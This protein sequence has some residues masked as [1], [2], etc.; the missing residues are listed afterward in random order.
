MGGAVFN[1]DGRLSGDVVTQTIECDTVNNVCTVPMR[2]PSF[3]LIFLTQQTES[4]STPSYTQ[5]FATTAT[6]NPAGH[7][8]ID[9]AVLATMNGEGGPGAR[10]TGST[11]KGALSAGI[12]LRELLPAA[13][14]LAAV[15]A[16]CLLVTLG[17]A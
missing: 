10:Y 5:T 6:T 1:S 8:A 12:G 3:A 17:R 13:W 4:E 16:G 7:P 11:A 15:V 14:S 2:A 9:P